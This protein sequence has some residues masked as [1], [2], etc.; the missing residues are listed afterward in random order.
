MSQ[1][2]DDRREG[3]SYSYRPSLLG[4][5]WEFRLGTREIEW[6]TGS[7]SGRIPYDKVRR[8]RLSYR[9]MSM[10]TRR[11]ATEIWATDGTC[12][13]IV[14]TSWKSM[15]DQQ[16]QDAPYSA[17]VRELH[18]RLAAGGTSLRCEQG[19]TP[20][21]YW[22][23]AIV[24]AATLIGLAVLILRALQAQAYAGA[25]FI[26]AFLLMFLWQGGNFFRLN[27]PQFYRPDAPPAD[28]L[29]RP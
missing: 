12:L 16:R 18:R 22:P 25:A 2:T 8:V 1:E 10:Q 3:A 7:K 13:T 17:F 26:L 21:I 14:S 19:K 28:L 9:P 15:L 23:G 5:P 20:W 11:F 4:A 6:T 29:P 24:F 27:R